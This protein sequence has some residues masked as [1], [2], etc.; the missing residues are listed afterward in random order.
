MLRDD[1]PRVAKF[2]PETEHIN[3]EF[4]TSTSPS[5]LLAVTCKK[6]GLDSIQFGYFTCI[7]I[8]TYSFGCLFPRV[9][10]NYC[11][12]VSESYSERLSLG[13]AVEVSKAEL[14]TS[15]VACL[16]QLVVLE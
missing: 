6:A 16:V 8:L 1:T 12:T 10:A 11:S 13:T 7:V 3:T 2:R 14:F 15:S 9:Y 4:P 5:V